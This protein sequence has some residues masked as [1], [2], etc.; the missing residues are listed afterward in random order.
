M[1][2]NISVA[3]VSPMSPDGSKELQDYQYNGYD[4]LYNLEPQQLNYFAID[5]FYDPY[6]RAQGTA[7][8]GDYDNNSITVPDKMQYRIDKIAGFKLPTLDFTP[9][10]SAI[11]VDYASNPKEKNN[12][13]VLSWKEDAYQTVRR[14]HMNWMN[15]WYNRYLDCMV[16]GRKGKYRNLSVYLF[17]YKNINGGQTGAPVMRAVPIALITFIGLVPKNLGDLEL[18]HSEPGNASSLSITYNMNGMEVFF[19]PYDPEDKEYI[20]GLANE[21]Q[22]GGDI[23]GLVQTGIL[24]TSVWDANGAPLADGAFSGVKDNNHSKIYYI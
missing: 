9:S 21:V 2:E 15:H 5:S 19:Y 13:L 4:Y 17:H 10:E 24:G 8:A 11:R 12:T 16:C 3:G 7:G 23:E 6:L 1:A 22:K 14:Y 18:N 20:G